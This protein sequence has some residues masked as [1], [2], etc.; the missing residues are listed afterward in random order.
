MLEKISCVSL[1]L[2]TVMV[3]GSCTAIVKNLDKPPLDHARIQQLDSDVRTAM[4]R[5]QWAVEHFA[6][7]HGSDVYPSKIDDDFKSY[8]PGGQD[9]TRPAPVGPVNVFS[10]KNEFPKLGEIKDVHAF[11]H[12]ARIDC[13]PGQIFYCQL[14]G[15][16]SYAIYG[17]AADG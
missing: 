13:E 5:V 11:R 16:K 2:V 14:E 8:M 6:A 9:G 17:G 3:L 15:G 4:Q 10:G 1:I 7:D 12:G